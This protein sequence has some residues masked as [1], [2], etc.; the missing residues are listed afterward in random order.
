M[1]EPGHQI[2]CAQVVYNVSSLMPEDIFLCYAL[3]VRLVPPSPLFAMVIGC[4]SGMFGGLNVYFMVN[5][6]SELNLVSCDCYNQTSLSI[7]LDG[8]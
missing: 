1:N 5:T 8:T 4:F 7:D 6:S 3:A 2:L